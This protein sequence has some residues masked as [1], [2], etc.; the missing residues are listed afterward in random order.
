V[1]ARLLVVCGHLTSQSWLISHC[2]YRPLRYFIPEAWKIKTREANAG[3]EAAK[4]MGDREA[5]AGIIEG[6]VWT[7][8]GMKVNHMTDHSLT[9]HA[10]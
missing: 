3:K 5:C 4:R 1:G 10:L 2:F 7:E 9:T 6:T 8:E